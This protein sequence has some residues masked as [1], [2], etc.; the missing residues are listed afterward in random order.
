MAEENLTAP[1][2]ILPATE[3]SVLRCALVGCGGVSQE[4]MQVYRDLPWVDVGACV[5][6]IPERAHAAASMLA[7]SSRSCMVTAD[8][9]ATLSDDIDVVVINTPNYLHLEQARAAIQAGK[10]V[11][12]QKP[13]TTTMEEGLL[14]LAAEAAAMPRVHAGMYIS[15]L[16]LP[17]V[18]ELIRMAR[19]GFF[20]TITQLSGRIMHGQGMAWSQEAQRQTEG[21]WRHSI[22]KTGGG[23]FIQLG[24]HYI[25]MFHELTGQNVESVLGHAANLHCPGI[26]G[27]DTAT[28]VL[29][30]RSGM[31]AS[32]STS[33]CSTGEELSIHGTLGSA[34]LLN[35]TELYVTGSSPW[36]TEWVRHKPNDTTRQVFIP[37]EPNEAFSPYNQHRLF[38][39]SVRHGTA[40]PV[41]LQKGIEDVAVVSAFYKSARSRSIAHVRAFDHFEDKFKD[42]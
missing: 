8:F 4:Y 1:D 2:F 35:N 38:L 25:R 22:H 42:K 12:L 15:Y 16:E 32:L 9:S 10:N 21:F 40:P 14:L 3:Q 33:W 23:A 31:V 20:G 17:A 18:Q 34:T 27:E 36:N 29:L 13:A 26:E 19:D 39:E 24:V 37:V 41:S 7:R 5:D 28:A 30:Y 6:I 11:L